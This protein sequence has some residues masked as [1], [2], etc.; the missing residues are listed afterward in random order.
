MEQIILY[1]ILC[2]LL[3]YACYQWYKLIP[4]NQEPKKIYLAI[5]YS[6]EDHD[7]SYRIANKITVDLMNK[8]YLVFSPIS[9][10]HGLENVPKDWK[11]WETFDTSM[12]KWA[13]ELHIIKFGNWIDSTGVQAEMKIALKLNKPVH[14]IRMPDELI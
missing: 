12:I 13:D 5:P 9:M 1:F 2:V 11:F 8:G 14:L 4:Q 7:L 3:T 6:K 10:S